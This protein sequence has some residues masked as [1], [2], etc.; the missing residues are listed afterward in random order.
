M[1]PPE[2]PQASRSPAEAAP[3]PAPPKRPADLKK[4][5]SKRDAPN[6][7]KGKPPE[8]TQTKAAVDEPTQR[9]LFVLRVVPAGVDASKAAIM[10]EKSAR[11]AAEVEA[12]PA[13]KTK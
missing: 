4:E 6:L 9:V 11:Q 3:A 5:E 13:A 7:A 2:E 8:V 1:K 10:L 12:A